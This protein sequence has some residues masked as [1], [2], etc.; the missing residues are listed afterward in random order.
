MDL[1][2]HRYLCQMEAHVKRL[3]LFSLV[4]SA[5]ISYAAD[6]QPPITVEQTQV[7]LN[8]LLGI[9]RFQI[10]DQNE[11]VV[12]GH[13]ENGTLLGD[14]LEA[15]L[16]DQHHYRIRLNQ[17]NLES[18]LISARLITL[19]AEMDGIKIKMNHL[20]DIVQQHIQKNEPT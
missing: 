19:E 20:K 3:L 4:A 15:M 12:N 1:L 17:H 14:V 18:Q 10:T 16:R 7:F 5:Y 11:I 9:S 13:I 6:N 8:M 2:S